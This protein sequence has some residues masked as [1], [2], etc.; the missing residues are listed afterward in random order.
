LKTAAAEHLPLSPWASGSLSPEHWDSPPIACNLLEA[1][2]GFPNSCKWFEGASCAI[3]AISESKS[4][5]IKV[6]KICY[7]NLMQVHFLNNIHE[8]IERRL[9]N[10]FSPHTLDFSNH[11]SLERC[12]ATLKESKV[13]VVIRV[14]KCWI[15]GW[16]TS[17][18]YH[19]DK[20]LPC[21]FGCSGCKDNLN[22]YLSCP[23]LFALWSYLSEG[24]SDL[25]LIR[26]GLLF[27]S[28]INHA[29]V[30]CVFSG[31]HAIRNDLRDNPV[32]L[33]HNLRTLPSPILRRAWSVFAQS[34]KVE[35]RELDLQTHQFSLPE[36]LN[37]IT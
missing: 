6:Q 17:Y 8:T 29:V 3:H 5:K 7:E 33:E 27:P 22:H 25:P 24:V 18:R 34:F 2:L 14:L 21:L 19:E 9:N 30:S 1:S 11:V 23:H 31:Y 10:L 36:F 16:A 28:K 35:A 13:S 37:S 4:D 20:L 15:N 26:W 32:F 12:L